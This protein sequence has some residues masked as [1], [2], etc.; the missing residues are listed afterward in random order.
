MKEEV[1]KPE[2]VKDGEEEKENHGNSEDETDTGNSSNTDCD[3]DSD[4]SFMNDTDAEIDTAEIEEEDW[5][6]HM[7]R[8]TEEAMEWMRTAKIH[9]WIKTHRRMKWRL[10]M[11]IASQF[12]A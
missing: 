9:C 7:K 2:K 8:S 5:I 10:A 4:I 1:G 6:D 11:K 3:Q 12:V